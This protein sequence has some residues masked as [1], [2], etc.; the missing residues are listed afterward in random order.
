MARRSMPES[1]WQTCGVKR[2]ARADGM[3]SGSGGLCAVAAR[4]VLPLSLCASG[5]NVSQREP[6]LAQKCISGNR[7]PMAYFRERA[8]Q[9]QS[10]TPMECF[11]LRG[12]LSLRIAWYVG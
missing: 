1:R 6:H 9:P 10:I 12:C 5:Y 3:R 4:N 7:S 11:L 8:W 2:E